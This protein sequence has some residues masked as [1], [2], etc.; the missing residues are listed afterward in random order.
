MIDTSPDLLLLDSFR[1]WLLN[2]QLSP[3][4]IKNY[5]S[6]LKGYFQTLNSQNPFSYSP[7]NAYL[8]EINADSNYP[9]YLASLNLFCQFGLNQK[10][11]SSNPLSQIKQSQKIQDNPDVETLINKFAQELNR[12]K[13]PPSTVKNYINDLYLYLRW[14]ESSPPPNAT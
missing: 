8:Q 1:S 9:R 6:D 3:S 12:L 4:T 11:I 7:L 5:V 14:L 13:T 2:R 10:L